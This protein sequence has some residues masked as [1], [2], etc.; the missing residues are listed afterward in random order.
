ME[1]EFIRACEDGNLERVKELLAKG[2]DP[3]YNDNYAIQQTSQYDHTKIVKMLL[4]DP[5]ADPRVDPSDD[6]NYAIRHSIRKDH[7]EILKLLLQDQRIDASADNNIAIKLA[8]NKIETLRL[9]I[10][11]YIEKKRL[12]KLV[13]DLR[14]V[15]EIGDEIAQHDS[16]F[17]KYWKVQ[18]STLLDI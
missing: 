3:L 6:D 10:D 14:K 8:S 15:K 5:R 12:F 11:W 1:K 9:L 18:K 7:I 13:N 2:V 17:A 16:R 4:A